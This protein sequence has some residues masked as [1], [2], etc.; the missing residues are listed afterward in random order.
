VAVA[1]GVG[2]LV[3]PELVGPELALVGKIAADC[4]VRTVEEI[5]VEDGFNGVKSIARDVVDSSSKLV[6]TALTKAK[7]VAIDAAKD[8]SNAIPTVNVHAKIATMEPTGVS[9]EA[10]KGALKEVKAVAIDVSHST[11]SPELEGYKVAGP[12]IAAARM[13]TVTTQSPKTESQAANSTIV[14][15]RTT[16]ESVGHC[17]SLSTYT[18]FVYLKNANGNLEFDVVQKAFRNITKVLIKRAPASSPSEIRTV[19]KN[20]ISSYMFGAVRRVF[21]RVVA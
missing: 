11:S 12:R 9:L 2:S 17:Q 20:S 18:P 10:E 6:A 8:L 7:V 21:N 19:P 15:S 16:Q 5:A 14:G 4:A 3:Q 1:I 13:P